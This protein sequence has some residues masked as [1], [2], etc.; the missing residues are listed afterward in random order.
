MR[1]INYGLAV[2]KV[3]RV[4]ARESCGM[5]I[6]CNRNGPAGGVLKRKRGAGPGVK[7]LE[8]IGDI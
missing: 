2:F 5:E 4:R 8:L 6:A 7:I 3:G 1:D